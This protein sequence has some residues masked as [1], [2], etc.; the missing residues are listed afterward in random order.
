MLVT[1]KAMRLELRREWSVHVT[2]VAAVILSLLDHFGG[3]FG[4][5]V[6]LVDEWKAGGRK[7]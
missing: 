4:F 3:V 2:Y 6:G 7:D 1:A 5:P